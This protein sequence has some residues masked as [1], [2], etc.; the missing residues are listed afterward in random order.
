MNV[1]SAAVALAVLALAA[2]ADDPTAAGHDADRV[3]VELKGPPHVRVLLREHEAAPRCDPAKPWH[4]RVRCMFSSGDVTSCA[5]LEV[6]SP[7]LAAAPPLGPTFKD[8]GAVRERGVRSR[9]P[10]PGPAGGYRVD[11]APEGD[12]IA[13]K[14]GSAAMLFYV[15]D[16]ATVG[17]ISTPWPVSWVAV[18]TLEAALP[19]LYSLTD[20]SSARTLASWAIR[21]GGDPLLVSVL[22]GL[23]GNMLD[24]WQSLYA[25]LSSDD[26]RRQAREA[27]WKKV[28]E[29]DP[30]YELLSAFIDVDPAL[31]P[32][33]FHAMLR[34]AALEAVA[35]DTQWA[36]LE[37]LLEGLAARDD[38]LAG[39]L[40]CRV[41]GYF[42]VLSLADPDGSSSPQIEPTFRDGPLALLTRTRTACPWVKVALEADPCA[43]SLRCGPDGGLVEPDTGP[44]EAFSSGDDDGEGGGSL[45]LCTRAVA[46]GVL[47]PP[48]DAGLGPE[49]LDYPGPLLLAAAY[50]QGVVS[51]ELLQ[52]NAR[53]TYRFEL[54]DQTPAREERGQESPCSRPDEVRDALCRLPLST[55]TFEWYACR[56]HIDDKAKV[57]RVEALKSQ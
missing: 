42:V 41:Y 28:Q 39:T 5:W 24:D 15:L 30:N 17:F 9:L 19:R 34:R 35:E 40:A 47:A 51:A 52:R 25:Q 55:T 46:E 21:T 2:C 1:R 20:A 4:E 22:A 31:H 8:C 23:D 53:R 26:A 13:V 56:A 12:R 16:G 54:P 6:D 29:P 38:P 18:P 3:A 11:V 37:P 10:A 43:R 57:V 44:A 27:L 45:P 49:A 7:A 32:P 33:D 14:V 48:T 36:T 50:R